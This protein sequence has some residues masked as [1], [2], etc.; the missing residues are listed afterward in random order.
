VEIVVICVHGLPSGHAGRA[1]TG[2]VSPACGAALPGSFPGAPRRALPLRRA[3]DVARVQPVAE[4]QAPV[5][6]QVLQLRSSSIRKRCILNDSSPARS[7]ASCH[8]SR[9]AHISN[10]C[11]VSIAFVCGHQVD[12]LISGGGWLCSS[13]CAA[14]GL[15]TNSI[16]G[17]RC[18]G[19]SG[20]CCLGL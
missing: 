2:R 13:S 12:A 3:E 18:G 17:L 5:R 6:N 16:C 8:V 9:S 11:H 4:Q 15:S 19:C 10:G 14:F 1:R 7:S 20:C